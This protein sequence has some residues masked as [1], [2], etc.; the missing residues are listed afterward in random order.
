[1][2][3]FFKI[4]N[5][6]HNIIQK[7]D[8]NY[9]DYYDGY[10]YDDKSKT[11]EKEQLQLSTPKTYIPIDG[12]QYQ[13]PP[14]PQKSVIYE[15]K[16]A[17]TYNEKKLWNQ[18]NRLFGEEYIITPQVPLSSIIRKKANTKYANELFRTIDFGIFTKT[19]YELIALIELNDN[20]H[21]ERNRI[22]RDYKVKDILEA[23]GI[24]NKLITLWI[25]KPNEDE[26]IIKRLKECIKTV[27]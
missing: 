25:D 1:M 13:Q 14:E 3:N 19:E 15:T 22:A 23:A 18:L 9:D 27:A 4:R 11:I 10:E 12:T 2:C 5:F 20:S 16:N 6:F 24:R 8:P 26:Y 17:M 7:I 21:Y